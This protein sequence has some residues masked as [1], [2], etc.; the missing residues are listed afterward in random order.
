MSNLRLQ[1]R[2]SAAVLKCGKGKIWLDPNEVN[3]ISNA[4]SRQNIRR[5]V[6]DGL[7]IRKPGKVHSRF[8]ARK[9]WRRDVRVVTW[10]LVSVAVQEMPECLRR[11]FGSDKIDKHL[12]HDLYLKAK[13]NAFKNKRNLMEYIFKKKSENTRSK[14][15]AEQAEA[16]RNKNKET[17]KRR[18][19]RLIIKRKELL[20]K[21][22][23]SE[24]DP[25]KDDK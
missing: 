7:I 16:R 2:L 19:E 9:P 23:E 12:Y 13:G 17:R 4:N 10:D 22:S 3:E 24:K 18:E 20:H 5:L 6:K 21:I 15:L 8:R 25:K 14:Q 1:K 11:S